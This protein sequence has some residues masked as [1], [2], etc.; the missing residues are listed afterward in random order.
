MRIVALVGSTRR[1]N[2]YAMVESACHV[3]SSESDVELIHLKDTSVHFCDGCLSCDETGECHIQD[4]AI[5]IVRSLSAADGLILGTPTRWS[6]LSGELKV[7]FDRLNPLAV[8]ETLAG[9][10]AVVFA[11][12]QSKPEDSKSVELAC[13]SVVNF[14]ENAGIEVVRTVLAFECLNQGDLIEKH[15]TVLAECKMAART[16]LS[17]LNN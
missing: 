5:E 11:V 12:G 3:L 16:L 2:T 13:R 1:G 17:A 6:L 10:K 7:L 9:K 15:S 8:S 4:G 14:C